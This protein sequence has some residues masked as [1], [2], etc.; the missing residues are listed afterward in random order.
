MQERWYKRMHIILGFF[1]VLFLAGAYA[2]AA[3]AASFSGTPT[4]G[5]LPLTVQFTDTSTGGPTGWTWYLGDGNWTGVWENQITKA[6]WVGRNLF[7]M[8]AL[9][10]GRLVLAGGHTAEGYVNDTW[11]STDKGITWALMNAS[12]G[13]TVRCSAPMAALPDGSL[14]ISG[15]SDNLRMNNETWLSLDKGQTWR[16]MN[17]SSGWTERDDHAMTALPDG[18]LVLAGGWDDVAKNDIWQSTDRGATWTL[19]NASAGW[20]GRYSHPM[21]ALPDGSLVISGGFD[22]VSKTDLWRSGDKGRTWM[23]MN[24]SS[25]ATGRYIHAMAGLPDGSLVITGG[26]SGFVTTNDDTW[27]SVDQ[28]ST[29]VL[30][31]A[32]SGWNPRYGHAMAVL[33]DGSIVLAGGYGGN[34]L[35]DTWRLPTAGSSVQNPVHVFSHAGTYSITLRS[36]DATGATVSTRS[37]YI[38]VTEPAPVA[39]FTGTP[40]TGT[41]PLTV[42]FT[43]TS[44]NSPTIWNWTFG[45]GS[46]VNAT[47]RN[48]VH[49]YSTAGVYTVNL[50]AGNVGGSNTTSL[51][52]YIAVTEPA[53]VA[54]FTGTPRTG[55]NP[56]TVVFTDT[57]TNSPTIWNWTFG[58]GSVV[59]ATVRNPVHTYSTAGVYT[60]NLTAGN[61]GG[62][63]TTSLSNYIT[64]TEPAPVAGFTGT[65][66][67]G[68]NPLTVVFTD[69]STNSPTIWNWTFGD[70]SVVNATVRN[71]VHTHSTAGVYTVN[72]T[73]GNVGG[74]NTT[75]LSNYISV[76]QYTPSPSA[77]SGGGSDDEPV[78][79]PPGRTVVRAQVPGAGQRTVFSYDQYPAQGMPV[80]IASVEITPARSIGEV[81][82]IAVPV[83][84][85]RI[86]V[87]DGIFAGV[88]RIEPV[89]FPDDSIIRGAIRFMVSRQWLTDQGLNPADMVLSRNHDGVWTELPTPFESESD[90]VCAYSA[91]T[92]GLSY[93]AV[94]IRKSPVTVTAT[95]SQAI[96]GAA[97]ISRDTM[98]PVTTAAI[99]APPVKTVPKTTAAT[100]APV[101]PPTPK[102]AIPAWLALAAAAGAACLIGIVAGARRRWRKQN[103]ARSE[104]Q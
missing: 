103:L 48:P 31:N 36:Y 33:P 92:P 23:Q 97:A 67:T 77:P 87:P 69:T 39:G 1:A 25:Q 83:Q 44:T 53:P 89:G 66:R 101:M 14:I 43:D 11:R 58:D 52:N 75:S 60:V 72:L 54:G 71:P 96:A 82:I 3:P 21:A 2:M 79:K 99:I 20:D 30:V 78:I 35:N 91:T 86:V 74:S 64:V 40:L 5:P 6:P 19:M 8:A 42:M 80:G 22:S 45:D 56:L 12:S 62:S 37:N 104:E 59:N 57:S 93:F 16:L 41:N 85:G 29:W 94:T 10:D 38:T 63:N 98:V 100:A 49:T 51:S 70:G 4:S 50:I 73:A 24:A 90:G 18:S 95:P 7:S 34:Y 76:S 68:T 46:V 17:A 81:E 32:S 65:P 13:W 15:G 88:V 27:R 61:V 26:Q 28:G 102:S 84:P 9:P 55:I 47:V